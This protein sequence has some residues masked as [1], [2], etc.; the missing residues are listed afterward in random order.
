MVTAS[1]SPSARPRPRIE[2][3]TT[4]LRPNGSTEVRI[5]SQRVAPSASAASTWS[6]GTCRNTSREI[7]EMIGRIMIARMMPAVKTVRLFG[8]CS[9]W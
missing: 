8:G 6:R 9:S 4:P 5:I 3:D 7:E 1:V 2:A